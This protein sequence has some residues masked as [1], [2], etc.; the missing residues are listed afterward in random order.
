MKVKVYK[1][2]EPKAKAP[3]GRK[4][5]PVPPRDAIVES[6]TVSR[7]ITITAKAFNVNYETMRRWMIN[8]DIPRNQQGLNNLT[9]SPMKGRVHSKESIQKRS[10]TINNNNSLSEQLSVMDAL[11]VLL[12]Q[13]KYKY[14]EDD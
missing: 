10:E 7:S 1:P 14:G 11:K 13:N 9:T 2:P 6:Y 3:C 5:L 4:L 8:L 12:G